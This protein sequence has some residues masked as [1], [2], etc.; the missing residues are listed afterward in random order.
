MTTPL[1]VALAIMTSLYAD[2]EQL[3]RLPGIGDADQDA[4]LAAHQWRDRLY[5]AA[6]AEIPDGESRSRA[7]SALTELRNVAESERRWYLA[8]DA[9]RNPHL[10]PIR[11]YHQ[12]NYRERQA[13]ATARLQTLT[14]Q[15]M[16][17]FGE[18]IEL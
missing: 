3:R 6:V 13:A 11:K 15:I 18:G 7:M 8:A 2:A 14:A 9:I 17:E 5:A 4:T 1:P 10:S 16:D 12:A